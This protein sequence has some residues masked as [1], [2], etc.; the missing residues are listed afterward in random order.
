MSSVDRSSTGEPIH[1]P[2]SVNCIVLVSWLEKVMDMAESLHI[3]QMRNLKVSLL[4]EL[5]RLAFNVR[6]FH[7]KL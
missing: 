1:C 3:L 5:L 2:N 7:I 4:S 6:S